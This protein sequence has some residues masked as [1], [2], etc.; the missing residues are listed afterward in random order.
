MADAIAVLGTGTMG[1]P[2][3]RNLADAGFEAR[4]WN[5]TREKAEPLASHGV[6]VAETA[7]DAGRGVDAAITMLTNGDAVH[8]VMAG[9]HGALAAMEDHALCFRPARWD[10]GR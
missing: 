2:M 10:C 9:G 1:A 5:R 7:S 3:A 8:E 4:A 6:E